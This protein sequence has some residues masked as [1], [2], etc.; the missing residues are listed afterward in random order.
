MLR[1]YGAKIGAA[2]RLAHQARQLLRDERWRHLLM[3]HNCK[4]QHLHR[5]VWLAEVSIRQPDWLLEG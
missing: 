2:E 3:H 4:L 5:L 1:A